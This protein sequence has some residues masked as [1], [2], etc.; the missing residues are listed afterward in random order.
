MT[1]RQQFVMACSSSTVNR[2]AEMSISIADAV[3]QKEKETQE[4]DYV[5]TPSIA[6]FS[7]GMGEKL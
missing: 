1:V 2:I 4:P 3:V 7:E 5:P 6:S